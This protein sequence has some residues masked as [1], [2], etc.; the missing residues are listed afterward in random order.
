MQ[1]KRIVIVLEFFFAITAEN[2]HYLVHAIG[3]A[4]CVK[5]VVL[6]LSLFS[7]SNVEYSTR[8]VAKYH[9]AKV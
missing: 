5:S 8:F 2:F 9:Q 7:G 4:E 1:S 6:S 3:Y